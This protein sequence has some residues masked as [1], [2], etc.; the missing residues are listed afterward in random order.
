MREA[1]RADRR[2]RYEFLFPGVGY[3]GSC[4]PKDV[5]ALIHTADS[6]GSDM[7]LL[8]A[9][10]QVNSAQKTA[11][12]SRIVS[13]FGGDLRSASLKGLRF[14]LWGLS[15]KPQTDD[16]RDAPALVIAARL[17]EL[18]ATVCAYDP[19][20]T[21]QAKG[22]LGNTIEYAEGMYEAAEGADAL[23]LVTEWKQFH[24]PSWQRLKQVMRGHVVFD[25]R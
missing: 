12:V 10:D 6:L 4:L 14:G 23:L 18:G 22:L 11:L 20:A 24:R 17:V 7:R 2:I 19:E 21:E 3:G 9:V 8:R 5:Q 15:F 13:H 16:M 25:G 1:I